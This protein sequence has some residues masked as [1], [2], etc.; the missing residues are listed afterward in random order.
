MKH[1]GDALVGT[2]AVLEVLCRGLSNGQDLLWPQEAS[3]GDG[4]LWISP[5]GQG[6]DCFDLHVPRRQRAR[7]PV[8]DSEQHRRTALAAIGSNFADCREGL[9]RA[10]NA[11]D[12]CPQPTQRVL[13]VSPNSPCRRTGCQHDRHDHPLHHH[14]SWVALPESCDVR[15][16][17]RTNR[18]GLR[19]RYLCF[20]DCRWPFHLRESSS[21]N[22]LVVA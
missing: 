8:R 16:K 9:V 20:V 10:L 1:P 4:D 18:R 7:M 15:P 12:L 17:P 3:D 22:L 14:A 19:M 6:L 21:Q 13:P 2:R 5:S 11:R